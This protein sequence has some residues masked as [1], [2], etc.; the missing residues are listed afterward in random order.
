MS[1]ATQHP[2]SALYT[3]T[4][5]RF[6][7]GHADERDAALQIE[8]IAGRFGLP[9]RAVIQ[10]VLDTYLAAHGLPSAKGPD[11]LDAINMVLEQGPVRPPFSPRRR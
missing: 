9:V 4:I 6:A 8:K 5:E 10:D 11:L 1:R 2:P 7:E 3:A